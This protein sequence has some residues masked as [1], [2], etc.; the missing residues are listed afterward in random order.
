MKD[1]VVLDWRYINQILIIW[2]G[3]KKQLIIFINEQNK[4]HKAIIFEYQ[5]SWQE[6]PFLDTMAYEDKEN[7]LE[8]SLYWKLTE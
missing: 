5:N 2:K 4:K 6:I 7:S 1:M 3:T 8:T